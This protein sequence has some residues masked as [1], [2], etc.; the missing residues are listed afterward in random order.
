MTKLK[1]LIEQKLAEMSE[2]MELVDD[3]DRYNE[4]KQE[5]NILERA[6]KIIVRDREP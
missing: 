3:R 6:L 5:V 4:L 2:L 1:K